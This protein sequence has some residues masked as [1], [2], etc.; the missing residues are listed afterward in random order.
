MRFFD[1]IFA[2]LLVATA[3]VGTELL[4]QDTTYSL[5]GTPGLIE[6]PTAQSASDA[7]IAASLTALRQQQ[8]ANFTF[9]LTP[10][11]SAT[12]RYTGIPDNF[13]PNTEGTFD[14]SFDLRYRILDEG[15]LTGWSPAIAIGLQD[16]IGTGKLS[17]EYLVASKSV[18][19]DI[20]V[21][22][23]LGFGRFGSHG[24]FKNPLSVLSSAAERRDTL[25]FGDG[26][27]I[28]GSQFFRG[29]A[30]LFGGVSW[31]YSEKLNL[32]AEYSSDAY[33]RENNFGTINSK[34][35]LNFGASYRYKPGVELDVAYLYG[36]ELAAGV[37]FTINPRIRSAVS[38]TETAPVPVASRP[39]LQ[40]VGGRDALQAALAVE[41]IRLLGLSIDGTT[42]RIR[43]VNTRY[44][45]EAQAMGRVARIMTQTMP[46][47]VSTF[48]ME[49]ARVG[50]ALSSTTLQRGD[51]KR[52]EN[53]AGAAEDLRANAQ[54]GDAAGPA[55]AAVADISPALT[56]GL[57]PYGK[58]IVFNGDAPVQ[59]D[60]G[61][62]LKGRYEIQ[63]NLF[64]AGTLRQSFLGARDVA[65]VTQVQ[66]DYYDVRTTAGE[67]GNDGYP[68]IADLFL[69]RYGRPSKNLYSRIDI[70][71]LES[72]YGGISTELLWKPV[73][74]RLA[75]GVE[76][77]YA[78]QRDTDML[79]DFA[80]YDVITGHVSAYLDIG[81]GFHG[82][83]DAGRYLA[84]DWGG[85]FALNRAFSNGWKVGAYFT[86]T[87]MPFEDYGEGSFDKGILVTVPFDYFLGNASQR[88]VDTSIASLTRDG[89]ARLDV[90]GRLYDIVRDGHQAGFMGDTW[91][92]FWR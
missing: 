14:R 23:G 60:V 5:Y 85:T 31:A 38:G 32:K 51:L 45:S 86:L 69:A 39:M 52:L 22:A 26:G 16:F 84:G 7:E 2:V 17:A 44:R 55:P 74:S 56:W 77:N 88:K 43:Y 37:T 40:Q 47:T 20:I 59:I 81:Y 36:T 66:N 11:L 15:R 73:N 75:V 76:A 41:D 3:P 91:G 13:G 87:D 83:V 8:R 80:E 61:L 89:G 71:Y 4:A 19:P 18:G 67:F 21:T 27:K 70:G 53:T 1:H 25:D 92:R 29:D 24:G 65:A 72:M 34:S 68:V 58:L 62:E 10:R 63:P 12:F 50:I 54:F 57:S 33:V 78:R 49:P 64:V 28:S 35:Q 82:Q 9:Q 48:V 79:F 90:D 6:M 46:A 42:A 30:A